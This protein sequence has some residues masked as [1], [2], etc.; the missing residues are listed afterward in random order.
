M[1]LGLNQSARLDQRLLQSP[2]MIQAMQILQLPA[3]ELEARIRQELEENPF[4]ELADGAPP[5]DGGQE[6]YADERGSD[7]ERALEALER[8]EHAGPLGERARADEDVDKKFE[9]MANTPELE[10]SLPEAVLG[11]L[12][13]FDWTPRE[14][15]IAEY[16]VWSLDQHGWLPTPREELL[17]E[18]T[19]PEEPHEDPVI[20][21]GE[22]EPTVAELESIL[23]RIRSVTHP[24]L[25]ARDLRECLLLQ[26]AAAGS[27]EDALAWQVVQSHLEDVEHN[28]LPKIAKERGQPIE[29]VKEAIEL[30]RTLD[31]NPGAGFGSVRADAILPEVLV[32]EVDGEWIV[33]LARERFLRVQLSPLHK[34]LLKEAKKGP[35]AREWVKKRLE[36]ARWFLDAL[37]QRESTLE[38]IAKAVFEHQRGF[39][40]KGVAGLKPLRMQE[41][42][43]EVGVHI[44]TVSRAVA[45]KHA[46]TPRGVLP[47]K[48]FFVGGTMGED[49]EVQSQASIK[50]RIADLI[51]A[52]DA[53]KPLSD[54]DLAE[55]LEKQDGV[56]IARRTVTKYRKALNLPSSSERRR[57]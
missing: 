2:Q 29:S 42:A 33:R 32:E 22:P 55:R 30:V 50:Q 15:D 19:H 17:R 35:E 4:L 43:D 5:E 18:L 12:A 56:K 28:R 21:K 1:R 57:F 13:L 47:L 40:E 37:Q 52:E 26:L 46:Q 24:G 10:Q 48:Y 41:I 11:E 9:A 39:L 44:S 7:G 34:E 6:D 38:R 51:R 14:R 31:P 3:L 53:A 54:E 20:A 16:L 49:G 27:G 45:G 25:F 8:L 23:A 36:N